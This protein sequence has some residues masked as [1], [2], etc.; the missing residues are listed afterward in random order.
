MKSFPTSRLLNRVRPQLSIFLLW[1][2][3]A[4]LISPRGVLSQAV[5]PLTPLALISTFVGALLTMRSNT[6]LARLAEGRVAWGTVVLHTREISQL[7]ATKVYPHTPQLAI[8]LTRHLSIFGWVLKAHIRG[9]QHNVADIVRTM[10]PAVD[11]EYV[12]SQRKLPVA[13]LYKLRQGIHQ[14]TSTTS[15]SSSGGGTTT[16]QR[17][18]LLT[19]AEEMAFERSIEQL[20][21]AIMTMERIRA[22]PIPPLYTSHTSRLLMFYLWFLPLALHQSSLT[23]IVTFLVSMVVGYTMLG[24]DEI[25]HLLEQPFRLMPLLQLSKI[26]MLDVGDSLVRRPPS[27]EESLESQLSCSISS[28]TT[29]DQQQSKEDEDDAKGSSAVKQQQIE[30]ERKVPEYW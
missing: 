20:D 21:H 24:L 30:E 18:K 19:T 14:L 27:I 4:I 8:L 16:N 9:T 26:S 17:R 10:L 22:S 3:I 25:S 15:V 28:T 12:L 2:I 5:I 6:G 1:T 29:M 7:L 11:A 23:G 13:I